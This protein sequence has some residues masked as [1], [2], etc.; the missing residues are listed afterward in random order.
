[1]KFAV[2]G[3]YICTH[4]TDTN[5]EERNMYRS[6]VLCWFQCVR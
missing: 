6:T 3:T 4:N 5:C 1:M 2:S